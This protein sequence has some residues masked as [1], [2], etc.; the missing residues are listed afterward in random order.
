MSAPYSAGFRKREALDYS[1]CEAHPNS[2]PSGLEED[3]SVFNQFQP[4]VY[5][6]RYCYEKNYFNLYFG[7]VRFVF[8]KT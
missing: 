3:G 8:Y 5:Q 2:P 7:P 1:T 6:Y 4:F